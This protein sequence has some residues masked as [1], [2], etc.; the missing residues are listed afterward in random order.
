[1]DHLEGL[2]LEKIES[3]AE[4]CS[5]MPYYNGRAERFKEWKFKI[6]NRLRIAKTSEDKDARSRNLAKLVSEAIDALSGDALQIAM[7]MTDEEL[8]AEDALDVL[9]DRIEENIN[10]N[11]EEYLR[12]LI[13][14]GGKLHGD[15][16]R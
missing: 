9:S 14:E 1:M 15:L 4:T 6:A 8:A 3:L 7:R 13:Q 10:T 5:G 12:K 2:R 11:K 16:C